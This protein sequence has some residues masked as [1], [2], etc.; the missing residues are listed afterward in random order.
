MI[1]G[2]KNT[3]FIQ[4]LPYG[5]SAEGENKEI[6]K[7]LRFIYEVYK[8]DKLFIK[9]NITIQGEYTKPKRT[10]YRNWLL[11]TTKFDIQDRKYVEK[12]DQENRVFVLKL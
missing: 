6:G 4:F 7:P 1:E 10:P 5:K 9:K 12:V 3:F 8:E 2:Q 11:K